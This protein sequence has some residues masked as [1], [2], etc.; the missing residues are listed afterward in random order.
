MY[1]RTNGSDFRRVRRP[2]IAVPSWILKERLIVSLFDYGFRSREI[3]AHDYSDTS[4]CDPQCKEDSARTGHLLPDRMLPS[5]PDTY[6]IDSHR[7]HQ[8]A[9]EARRVHQCPSSVIGPTSLRRTRD[10]S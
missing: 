7:Q 9:Q 1:G 5:P 4:E 3:G 10:G 8:L 6:R 2:G